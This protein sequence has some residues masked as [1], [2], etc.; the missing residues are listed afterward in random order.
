[1]V[2]LWFLAVLGIAGLLVGSFLNV[3]ISRI[4][5]GKSIIRP[6][7]SCA[8]CRYTISAVD[9]IPLISWLL[10]RGQCRNCSVSISLQYPA[11]EALT[12]LVWLVLGWWALATAPS[13]IWINPLLPLM[14]VFGSVLI[15]LAIIDM[16][17]RRLPNPIVYFLYPV[18][19]VGLMVAAIIAGDLSVIPGLLLS[20]LGGALLW[21]GVIGGLWLVSGGKAMGLGDAKLAPVLGAILGWQGFSSA[22]LGLLA[23]FIVGACFGLLLLALRQTHAKATIAFGPFLIVGFFVGLVAGPQFWDSY[24][25]LVGL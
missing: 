22:A 8:S 24:R 7:S 9:N 19:V 10:L 13:D 14:L 17:W 3:V 20:S 12:G 21:G 2:T 1:M 6:R 15:S 5:E 16:K 4:P 11:V 23:A 18:C 25:A